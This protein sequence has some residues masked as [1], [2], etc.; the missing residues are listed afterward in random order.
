MI[1]DDGVTK[2]GENPPPGH[3]EALDD[4]DGVDQIEAIRSSHAEGRGP[5]DHAGGKGGT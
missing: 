5:P 3:I 4:A 2:R 1:V